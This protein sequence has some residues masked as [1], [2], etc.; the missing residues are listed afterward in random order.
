[1]ARTDI[2]N[3]YRKKCDEIFDSK[4]LNDR[5]D[6]ALVNHCKKLMDQHNI[7]NDGIADDD[8]W[9][10][11]VYRAGE[12]IEIEENGYCYMHENG[13]YKLM[14]KQGELQ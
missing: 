10:E 5:D 8:D 4:N 2:Q 12:I 7:A 14:P 1:M 11:F 6:E 9:L 13:D 3:F